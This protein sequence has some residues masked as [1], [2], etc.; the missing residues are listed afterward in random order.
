[1]CLLEG[2]YLILKESVWFTS[3]ENKYVKET[4]SIERSL[5]LVLVRDKPTNKK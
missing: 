4:V 2:F 3:V 1:M 5:Y